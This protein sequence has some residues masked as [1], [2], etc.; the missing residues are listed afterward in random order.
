MSTTGR[1]VDYV[2][3]GVGVNVNQPTEM[4]PPDLQERATSLYVETGEIYPRAHVLLQILSHLGA[5]YTKLLRGEREECVAA[6]KR[7]TSTLGK[8]VRVHIG[9]EQI[10]GIAR[11]IDAVG[12]LVIERSDGTWQTVSAGEILG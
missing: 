12:A 9:P 7:V 2:I 10:T 6:W 8:P 3:L 5:G 4:W 1:Q 11:D